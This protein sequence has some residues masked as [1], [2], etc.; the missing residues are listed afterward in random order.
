M[1]LTPWLDECCPSPGHQPC[2]LTEGRDGWQKPAEPAS[3]A[4]PYF[5]P[6]GAQALGPGCQSAAGQGAGPSSLERPPCSQ[7]CQSGTAE[8]HVGHVR[9]IHV[10]RARLLSPTRTEMTRV[11]VMNVGQLQS[12]ARP[13]EAATPSLGPRRPGCLSAALPP[14]PG[15]CSS[16]LHL[17]PGAPSTSVPSWGWGGAV[18]WPPLPR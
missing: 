2:R 14:R 15:L 4:H 6:V 18:S 17:H 10:T 16:S 3:S 5:S 9:D 13:H 11:P 12:R 1:S 7:Q 8:G